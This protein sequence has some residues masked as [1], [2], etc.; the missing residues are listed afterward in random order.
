MSTPK[1]FTGIHDVT[2]PS[3]FKVKARKPS[4]FT[5]V[6]SGVFPNELTAMAMKLTEKKKDDAFSKAIESE[7][8]AL[9]AFAGL[10]DVLLARVLADPQVTTDPTDCDITDE[11]FLTGKI[12]A[13]DVDDYDKQWLFLWSQ[14]LLKAPPKGVAAASLD[15]FRDGAERGVA[16]S[17]GEAVRDKAEPVPAGAQPPAGA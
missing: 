15:T 14:S 2:L 1:K 4:L 6:S 10:M 9:K 17:G 13:Q 7:P 12:N 11:N 5:L 3:G 16:G 8:D